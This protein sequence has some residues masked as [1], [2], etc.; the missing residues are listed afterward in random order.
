MEP[1]VTGLT[2]ER[3]GDPNAEDR[4][5]FAVGR[6]SGTSSAFPLSWGPPPGRD[7]Q[8]PERRQWILDHA[9]AS[10]AM[11][12]LRQ[13]AERDAALTVVIERALLQQRR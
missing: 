11:K 8:D 12:P 7:S 6:P 10:Q 1:D 4:T 5:E 13:L 3:P 2:V 9:A